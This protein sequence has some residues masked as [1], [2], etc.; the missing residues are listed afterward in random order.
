MCFGARASPCL[1]PGG[2]LR[3]R[4]G[5]GELRLGGS[6]SS[7]APAGA[8][9]AAFAA[10]P[11]SARWLAA[12]LGYF[13]CQVVVPVDRRPRLAPGPA[14]SGR[15]VAGSGQVQPDLA[16]CLEDGRSLL[17]VGVT[18]LLVPAISLQRGAARAGD[19][20]GY[21]VAAMAVTCCPTWGVVV[22][23]C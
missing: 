11:S 14:V 1:L 22:A 7:P 9:C 19:I 16:S 8:W 2:T 15:I 3:R 13:R 17:G 12:A 18:F 6:W 20:H 21:A 4:W 5:L 10:R 23:G